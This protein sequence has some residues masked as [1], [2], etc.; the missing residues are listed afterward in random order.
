MAQ[1]LVIESW[2]YVVTKP[3]V[4]KEPTNSLSTAEIAKIQK[5]L[6]QAPGG[7][8]QLQFE[9][10]P[11][12]ASAG[13]SNAHISWTTD[14]SGGS[15]VKLIFHVKSVSLNAM[16]AMGEEMQKLCANVITTLPTEVRAQAGESPIFRDSEINGTSSCGASP[17]YE[18]AN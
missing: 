13:S 5:D 3:R 16:E 10:E 1:I 17:F 11:L 15:E 9:T 12:P 8:F 18:A 2:R 7:G 6:A 4:R 14:Y